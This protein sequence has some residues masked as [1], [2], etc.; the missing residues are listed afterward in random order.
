LLPLLWMTLTQRAEKW[1]ATYMDA[2]PTRSTYAFCLDPAHP[3][4]FFLC[5]KVSKAMPVLS[6]PIKVIPHAYQMLQKDY[7]DMRA[8]CNGFKLRYQNEVKTELARRGRR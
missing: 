7:P 5:F 3:G 2:N 8:V 1:I 4:Y 6:W